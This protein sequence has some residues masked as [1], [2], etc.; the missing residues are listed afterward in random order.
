MFAGRVYLLPQWISFQHRV[1][2]RDK[3][4]QWPQ[5]VAEAR[6]KWKRLREK[7]ELLKLVSE[8]RTQE[9]EEEEEKQ[10]E[11]RLLPCLVLIAFCFLLFLHLA[12]NSHFYLCTIPRA[13]SLGNVSEE[14]N[15]NN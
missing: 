9:E 15:T 7:I 12:D 3:Y 11:L 6:R 2:C 4:A 5:C 13:V 10:S 8:E 1:Y 14:K